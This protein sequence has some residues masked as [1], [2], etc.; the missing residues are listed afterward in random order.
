VFCELLDADAIDAEVAKE[1]ALIFKELADTNK[2]ALIVVKEFNELLVLAVNELT[3]EVN[4]LIIEPVAIT[5]ALNVFNEV[6]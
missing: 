6:I 3:D 2:L 1:L 5:L 4:V